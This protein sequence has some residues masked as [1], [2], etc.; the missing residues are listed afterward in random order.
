M[1]PAAAL[2]TALPLVVLGALSVPALLPGQSAPV[3]PSVAQGRGSVAPL[4]AVVVTDGTPQRVVLHLPR[5]PTAHR[6]APAAPVLSAPAAPVARPEAPHR[7]RSV[8]PRAPKVRAVQ[9]AYPWASDTTQGSD[10]WGFT[11]RQCVSYVAW[12]LAGVGHALDNATQG[13]GSALTWDDTARR[14][15]YRVGSRPAVGAVAHWDEHESGAYWSPGAASSD[16][17]YV[18]GTN[19][20]VAWVVDVYADGSVLVA[21]YNGT[22]DRAFST[23]R[24][25]APRYL[26]L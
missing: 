24:V 26:Y 5:K 2:R 22:V 3:A 17:S 13:W 1:S 7:K 23:M 11:M 15:G 20:H 9:D 4:T 8:A 10:P 18:A 25:K 16:G 12:R 19:G 6:P 14:L 21:Q